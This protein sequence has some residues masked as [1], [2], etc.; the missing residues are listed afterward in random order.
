M[1]CPCCPVPAI[2]SWLSGLG[3][4]AMFV[5]WTDLSSCFKHFGI[6]NFFR[7]YVSEF[8]HTHTFKIFIQVFWLLYNTVYYIMDIFSHEINLGW[9]GDYTVQ[10]GMWAWLIARFYK[11]VINRRKKREMPTKAN[12]NA[13]ATIIWWRKTKTSRTKASITLL[14][15]LR[16]HIVWPRLA[17]A[18]AH[19][20]SRPGSPPGRRAGSRTSHM[21]MPS[22]H[23]PAPSAHAPAPS[24][25]A[26]ANSTFCFI[27]CY[28]TGHTL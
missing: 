10:Y 2:V 26:P 27:L 23:A 5:K 16:L 18:T 12:A 6:L 11:Q 13:A 22:A 14:I 1:F 17:P 7:F 8:S 28:I 9:G 3:C 25:H 4:S 24:A 15:D 19:G 20:P 21:A